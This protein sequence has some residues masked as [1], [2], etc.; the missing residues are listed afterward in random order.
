M[1]IIL[2]IRKL[3][4]LDFA[5]FWLLSNIIGEYTN[6]DQVCQD[7]CCTCVYPRMVH[8]GLVVPSSSVSRRSPAAISGAVVSHLSRQSVSEGWRDLHST[9]QH[10]TVQYSGGTL[11][12]APSPARRPRPPAATCQYSHSG[13]CT[14]SGG[15]LTRNY[16]SSFS[17]RVQLQLPTLRT[18]PSSWRPE[19]LRWPSHPRPPSPPR[20]LHR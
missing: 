13:H 9:V 5:R 18:P 14:A 3:L 19:P 8:T 10:S 17:C 12:G 7:S 6:D 2:V 15:P 16:D 1:S 11:A 4:L 20:P